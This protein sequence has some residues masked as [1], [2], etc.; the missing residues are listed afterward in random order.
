MESYNN[1]QATD[2]LGQ[3]GAKKTKFVENK[4]QHLH[5]M[6]KSKYMQKDTPPKKKK[7]KSELTAKQQ[8]QNNNKKTLSEKVTN[9]SFQI[10]QILWF[11]GQLS[12]V[13]KF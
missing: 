3:A 5:L 6:H 12:L 8:Q 7:K 9:L 4:H 11:Q 10:Q 1:A 13:L 2:L